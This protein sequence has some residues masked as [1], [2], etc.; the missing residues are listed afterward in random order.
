M[1]SMRSGGK[2]E[3]WMMCRK[4]KSIQLRAILANAKSGCTDH[5]W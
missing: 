2:R 5:L 3:G 4:T 1:S